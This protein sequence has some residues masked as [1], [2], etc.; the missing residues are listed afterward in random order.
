MIQFLYRYENFEYRHYAFGHRQRRPASPNPDHCH[1]SGQYMKKITMMLAV[2]AIVAFSARGQGF[3]NLNFES[4]QNL[5][6]NPPIPDG[7]NVAATNALPGWTAYNGPI[8]SGNIL[9]DINYVS[10]FFGGYATVVELEGGSLALSGDFSIE[11]GPNGLISQTA[12]VPEDAESL[13]FEATTPQDGLNVTLGGQNLSYSL[14]SEGADYGVY[15]ANIPTSLD[16]Q[17]ETLIFGVQD[18]QTLLDNIT[19]STMSVPEPSECALMGLGST[20]ALLV[21]RRRC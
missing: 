2:V 20:I 17:I 11:L 16:G 13:E 3:L 1:Q 12:V 4:A 5:P 14:L 6:G 18:G 7:A 19:F 10:N 21:L 8:N 15:G 9:A